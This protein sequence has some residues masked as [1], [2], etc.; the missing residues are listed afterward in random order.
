[1]EPFRYDAPTSLEAALSLL[2]REAA[3]APERRPALLAGGTDLIVQLR[4]GLRR[5]GAVIDLK[6]VPELGRVELGPDGLSLGA[7][8]PCAALRGRE[9]LRAL[10]PGLLEAA[11]LIGSMQIQGRATVVGNLCNASPAAD[12]VPAL[13][14]LAARVRVAGPSGSRELPVS[15]FCVGPGR[16]ALAPDE[17]ATAV[18]VPR[19]PPRS[20]DAY[21]RFTPRAE[22][23]IAVV[24]AA[25]SLALAPDGRCTA[26]RVALGAVAERALLAPAA[27]DALVGTRLEPGAL[28][29]A[30]EAARAAARPID[31]KRGT[32]SFRRHVAGVLVARA[33][34]RAA[35]RAEVRVAAERAGAPA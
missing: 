10:W 19:P 30:A 5:P 32:A 18:L 27:A 11:E 3:S 7:A 13:L 8:V 6:R 2:A 1:V 25:V 22:M 15:D 31:D 28:E 4:A 16:N 29:R 9:D 24:G 23:D 17:L 34:R 33:A 12:T 14:A 20:A 35:E 26:A 21:L